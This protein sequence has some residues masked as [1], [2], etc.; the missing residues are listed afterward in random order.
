MAATEPLLGESELRHRWQPQN[1]PDWDPDLPYGGKVYLARKKKPDPMHVRVAEA[2]VIILTLSFAFYAYFYFD[3]LHFRVTHAYAWMGFPQA[4]H[5]V[6]Q[7]YLNGKGVEKHGGKAMEWFKKAADQGHPHAKYNL[8]IGH[9]KGYKTPLKPG[10]A[11]ELIAHA[12]ANGVK[13]AHR[14]LNEVCSRGG[15]KD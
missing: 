8:A 6:G 9:L 3:H 11:H 10:E 7:R 4:Q 5:Q 1:D 13:E 2:V 15:C 12:A 14:V